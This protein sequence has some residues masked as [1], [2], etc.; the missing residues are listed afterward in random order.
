MTDDDAVDNALD[1]LPDPDDGD[2]D[3]LAPVRG[4]PPE[5]V[6]RA[7]VEDVLATEGVT[8][9]DVRAAMD[10][11]DDAGEE[12]A[13]TGAGGDAGGRGDVAD[14]LAPVRGKTP[15]E[16]DP[17]VVA[18][19]LATDGVDE[20]DMLAA[21]DVEEEAEGGAATDDDG[22]ETDDRAE[23][24]GH[25]AGAATTAVAVLLLFVG[26]WRLFDVTLGGGGGPIA[27]R[28][29]GSLLVS[30]VALPVCTLLFG[31]VAGAAYRVATDDVAEDYR[32]DVAMGEFIVPLGAGI[33]GWVLLWGG[34]ALLGLVDGELVA[35]IVALGIA[36][37]GGF[38]FTAV[39]TIAIALY[40]GVPAIVGTYV[41]GTA[42]GLLDGG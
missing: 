20:D 42:A 27:L 31:V 35:A 23:R 8:E 40:L 16:V 7:V 33:V 26:P 13:D 10:V 1:V 12:R 17:A 3:P 36:F 22:H 37:L 2:D 14:P 9:A 15:G 18:E 41:G 24:F 4:E 25:Y 11:D 21:M 5:A 6:D 29:S 28:E 34:V 32:T 38:V 30:L 19:V 39:E